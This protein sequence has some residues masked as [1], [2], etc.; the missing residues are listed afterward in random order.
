[1]KKFAFLMISPLFDPEV[2]K[3]VFRAEGRETHIIYVKDYEEAKKK[4]VE[5]Y[6]DGF[7][8]M[9]LCSAFGRER[10]KELIELTEGKMALGYIVFDPSQAEAFK[11]FFGRDLSE[12][13]T[14]K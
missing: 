13:I 4:V 10:T 1:M 12:Q 5:L 9:E 3:A 7:G 8:A 6:H 2:N 11:S 14:G